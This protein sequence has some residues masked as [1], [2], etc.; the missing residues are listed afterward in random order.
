M[1]SAS[2]NLPSINPATTWSTEH[3]TRATF[4]TLP[5]ELRQKILY[6]SNGI[7]VFK[8]PDFWLFNRGRRGQI[9]H[10][11]KNAKNRTT[12]Q[13]KILTDSLP[14]LEADVE[15][16][17]GLWLNEIDEMTELCLEDVHLILGWCTPVKMSR[18]KPYSLRPI[19]QNKSRK[20]QPKTPSTQAS[21]TKRRQPTNYFDLPRELRQRI[22]LLTFSCGFHLTISDAF[23]PPEEP[24][25]RRKLID[26]VSEWEKRR[27]R[28]WAEYLGLLS[29]KLLW[30]EDVAYV[31]RKMSR[32][33]DRVVVDYLLNQVLGIRRTHSEEW[34][35]RQGE[36]IEFY[37]RQC[38]L[39]LKCRTVGGH[40][41]QWV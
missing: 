21:A 25:H 35:E 34:Y 37:V 40:L 36:K 30:R 33:V 13:A 26:D 17:L 14:G 29:S 5:R 16:V 3:K 32:D 41:V 1:A 20:P 22:L 7:H 38:R 12:S 23:S 39:G 19:K 8:Q 24:H 11:G 10:I 15:Y 31:L 2:G 18:K 27:H 28:L 6:L 9:R 4:F